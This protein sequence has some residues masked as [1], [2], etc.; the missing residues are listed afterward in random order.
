M[1]EAADI[2]LSQRQR[3]ILRGVVEGYVS[4]GE[5]VGS[6]TLVERIRLNASASTVRSE[7]AELEARGLLMHPHTSAG[8]VPTERGYRYYADR[9]LERLD[10]QPEGFPLDLSSARSEVDAALEATTE[11]L[12]ELTRLLALVSAP[13]LGT[14][15]VRH[16]EVLV[17]QPHVVMVV[18][19]TSTGSVTKSVH[20][21]SEPVDSGLVNWAAQYLNERVV[22]LEL[23]SHALRRR[24]DDP[25]LGARESAFL[26]PVRALFGEAFAAEGQSLYVGGTAGLLEDLREEELDAYQRLLEV[27]EERAALLEVV[28][29]ALDS[30]RPFVRLGPELEH[31]GMRDLAL[32]G[33]S[34]GLTNRTLGAVTLVGPVRMDYEKALRSVRAAAHELSRFVEE[35]Y[36]DN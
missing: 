23:G 4:T 25:S 8:R 7:L 21:F 29:Q 9:V 11:M 6:R 24:L 36:E 2:D 5:P 30:R 12:S 3:E 16:V 13:P 33:A 10:P 20:R 34:Y 35:I 28:S 17:L 26:E 14:A 27:L 32:V 18:V 22:G 31:P 1:R 15:T 19:I